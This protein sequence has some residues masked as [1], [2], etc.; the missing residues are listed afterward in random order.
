MADFSESERPI[1]RIITTE[2]NWIEGEAIRQLEN[3][4]EL[5]GMIMAVGLPELHPGKGIPVGAVFASVG[6]F[7]PYLVGNDVGCGM[8]LWKTDLKRRK[9]KLDRWVER[10]DLESELAPEVIASRLEEE[11]IS[12]G[13]DDAGLGSIGGGN[14]FAE[15]QAIEKVEDAEL[16]EN[17][18]L[19]TDELVLLVHSGSR[20]VGEALLRSHVDRHKAEGLP[21]TPGDAARY[22]AG[23]VRSGA[24]DTLEALSKIQAAHYRAISQ[25]DA[26]E[27]AAQY[28]A[29]QDHALGWARVNRELIAKRFLDAVGGE[30]RKILDLCHNSIAR[31]TVGGR[32]CWLHRK[33][34][35]P[36]ERPAVIAGS[37]GALSYLV[38]PAGD[39]EKCLYS[40]THGAG[41]KW[42]RGETKSRLRSH[43]KAEGLTRTRLGGRVICKD[44]NL[45]YE[46]APQA[47]KNIETV[48]KALLDEGLIR[49]IA[50][51]RPVI[52][53]KKREH[54]K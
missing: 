25:P 15:L 39:Q 38:E 49:V 29:G 50:T 34:A 40:I 36:S 52:T 42:K 33:G 18:E 41:R 1:V 10:L 7:Y 21:D 43:F 31:G 5:P 48:V 45:L 30:G 46:E 26:S 37:R 17:L 27:D 47:Y 6:V 44:R 53:Y 20:G 2:N 12:P 19:S 8:A 4:A 16:F 13:P 11:G 9:I 23:Q 14:H 3:T 35:V 54:M 22:L 32:P 51:L 28:L 24:G